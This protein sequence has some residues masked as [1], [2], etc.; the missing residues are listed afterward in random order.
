MRSADPRVPLSC[1]LIAKW[2]KTGYEKLCWYV[3]SHPALSH[4]L[5]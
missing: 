2:K 1:S 4:E 3:F 5:T